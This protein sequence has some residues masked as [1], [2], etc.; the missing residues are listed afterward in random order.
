MQ[1]EGVFDAT[2]PGRGPTRI[3]DAARKMDN[4]QEIIVQGMTGK[5]GKD[6]S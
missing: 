6:V 3:P 4:L 1:L 2:A 5:Y